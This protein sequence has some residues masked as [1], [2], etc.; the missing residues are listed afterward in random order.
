MLLDVGGVECMACVRKAYSAVPN[1][2]WSPSIVLQQ[3]S[4]RSKEFPIKSW[5][6]VSGSFPGQWRHP[7]NIWNS[8]SIQSD[9]HQRLSYEFDR[10]SNSEKLISVA[11]ASI[12]A[13]EKKTEELPERIGSSGLN[14]V[15]RFGENGTTSK[16]KGM[17]SDACSAS[18]SCVNFETHKISSLKP[19]SSAI[20]KGDSISKGESS[21]LP[22]GLTGPL[23]SMNGMSDPIRVSQ[24]IHN[25]KQFLLHCLNNFIPTL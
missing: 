16:R 2:V 15:H 11:R 6:Q 25:P 21:S 4:Q 23:S 18:S 22:I 13:Q 9:L 5:N 3:V 10:P 24:T 1:Q 17:L 12:S 8:S 20:L 19:S 14:H 7:S